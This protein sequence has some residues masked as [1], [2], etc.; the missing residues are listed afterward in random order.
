MKESLNIAE[1]TILFKLIYKFNAIF[2]K[3]P[4]G[5]FTEVDKQIQKFILKYKTSRIDKTVLE[6]NKQVAGPS[7]PN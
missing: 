2:I 4:A 1:M 3:V 5:L 7:L 6:A